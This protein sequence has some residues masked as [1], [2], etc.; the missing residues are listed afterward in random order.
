MKVL[1]V[2]DEVTTRLLL[3]GT[4]RKW[5]YEVSAV[6]DGEDGWEEVKKRDTR[7]VITDWEMPRLD[8]AG[9]CKRI[10]TQLG[11][12]YIYVLLLTNYKDAEHIVQGLSAGADDFISK[13]FNPLELQARMAVG[14]RILSLQDDLM[15]KNRELERLNLQLARIAATDA[16]TQLGNRRSFD[17]ALQRIHALSL[18][19]GRAYGMLM[20]DLDNFKSVND[21]FGHAVGDKVLAEVAA[22]FRNATRSE[23][24]LFRYGGE[25]IAVLTREQTLQGLEALC[26]R[27]CQAAAAV[28]IDGGDG[29]LRIT[30]SIGAALHDG[31]ERVEGMAVVERADEVMYAAKRAGRNRYVLWRP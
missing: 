8:G 25:E 10:R 6:G 19:H 9:L 18:R 7:L 17:D 14:Q 20:A 12:H 2:E 29:P 13:P 26:E 4:L 31:K 24:E 30:V 16:L 21:R 5:G 15:E 1:V 22:A 3:S 27:L 11:S 28:R 23:D